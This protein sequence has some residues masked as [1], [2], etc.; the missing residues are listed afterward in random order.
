[1]IVLAHCK[2]SLTDAGDNLWMQLFKKPPEQVPLSPR[3]KKYFTE[4]L[5]FRHRPEVGRVNLHS[6][7]FAW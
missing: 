4:E 3:T 7:A 6:R 5:F 1:L 2:S